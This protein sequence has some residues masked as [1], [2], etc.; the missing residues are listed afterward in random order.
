[1]LTSFL[2]SLGG[3]FGCRALLLLGKKGGS[4]SAQLTLVRPWYFSSEDKVTRVLFLIS[5][6]IPARVL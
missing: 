4:N 5:K 2:I 3:S 6:L 1:M